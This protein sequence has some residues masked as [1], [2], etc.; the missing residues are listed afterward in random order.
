MIHRIEIFIDGSWL[1]KIC[2]HLK[3]NYNYCFD[4]S[5]IEPLVLTYLR[6]QGIREHINNILFFCSERP[7]S[8][9]E[10]EEQ[11]LYLYLEWIGFK[12]KRHILVP[13]GRRFIE[14]M[15]DTDLV[16]HMAKR[17]NKYDIAVL[18]AGDCDFLPLFNEL[19][20]KILLVGYQD[21]S[22]N[23]FPTS[24]K[25]I[26]PGAKAFPPLFLNDDVNDLCI[27]Y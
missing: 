1:Y 5:K 12:V 15:V 10:S 20:K 9:W 27:T 16:L 22:R 3:N 13:K 2:Q 7:N 21:I 23:F 24:K 25:L 6:S 17:S 26:T 11:Q 8:H 19:G 18:V 14:K 4:Y